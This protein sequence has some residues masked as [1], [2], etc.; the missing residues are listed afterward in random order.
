MKFSILVPV[1]NVEKYLEQCVDSLLNQTF[2][3]KYEIILVDDGSTDSSGKICDRYAENNPDKIRVIHKENGGH[4]SARLEAIRN[5]AGEYCLF[6]DSDDFVENSLL[7]TVDNVLNENPDTDMVMYSFSYY[8]NGRKKTRK[9]SVFEGVEFFE[10]NEKKKLCDLLITTP[11]L[12]SL[13]TK[14]V[15][16]EILKNDPTDYSEIADRDIAEDAYIISYFLTACKKI[17]NIDKPLYNY[18]TNPKGI[19]RSYNPDKIERKNM[20]FL[21]RRFIELLP[22]WGMDNEKTVNKIYDACLSNAMYLFRKHYEYAASRKARKTILEYDWS[23]MLFDEIIANPSEY[24]NG[25]APKLFHM[26]SGK[27]YFSLKIFFLKNRI[28]NFIKNLKRKFKGV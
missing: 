14:A 2:K 9:I 5:A 18:R 19:S 28:Y 24:G 17:I 23:S 27:K 15:R 16:T 11:H 26:L 22:E 8:E 6:S 12:N 10:G 13:W 1:Y 7:E 3:G 20:L 21:Y 25:I 4:T